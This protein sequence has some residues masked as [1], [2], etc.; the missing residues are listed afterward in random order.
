VHVRFKPVTSGSIKITKGQLLCGFFKLRGHFH[1]FGQ[2]PGGFGFRNA[3]ATASSQLPVIFNRSGSGP[4][5]VR[6]M[7]TA[8]STIAVSP[9]FAAA[10]LG[11]LLDFIST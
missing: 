8:F 9:A 7:P 5:L 11:E 10:L 4:R 2:P 6:F 3:V 1:R